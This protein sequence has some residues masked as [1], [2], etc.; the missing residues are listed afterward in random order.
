MMYAVGLAFAVGMG[1]L[2]VRRFCSER[3]P[4]LLRWLLGAALGLGIG[5]YLVFFTHLCFNWH[6]RWVPVF[7]GIVLLRILL[8]K[9]ELRGHLTYLHPDFQKLSMVSPYLLLAAIAF[10]LT[11]EAL[12]FPLGG[13]DAWSCWN[14]K[15]KF[16]YLGKEHWRDLFDP[17]LWRSNTQY[18]LLLPSINVWFWDFTGEPH[19]WVPMIN[20]ILITLLCAA[21]LLFGL[22]HLTGQW[23]MPLILTAAVFLLPFNITLSAG[24][25]SDILVGL[26]ILCALVCIQLDETLLAAMF[27][28]LLSFTKTEGLVAAGILALLIFWK[29]PKLRPAFLGTLLAAALPTIIFMLAMAPR[30]E[31][32]INGLL[33]ATKP[34][35]FERLQAVLA[36]PWFEF[37]SGKWNGLW[38]VLLAGLAL[39]WKT[40]FGRPLLIFGVFFGLYLGV[41]L[42]YYQIN[43][44]FEIG[45]WLQNTFSRI[46]FALLPSLMLWLGLAL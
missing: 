9:T 35:T 10:F 46:L 19:A 34:S 20:G 33:S 40:A 12:F 29:T 5:G 37:F 25:Y 11:C 26:Y 2:L 8:W 23:V 31:A 6:A 28:G 44:F 18:P 15:A 13:W 21:V 27:L 42:A 17:L 30:N 38:I 39:Q 22:K 7:A 3:I 24:Q 43:T 32:F 36:Y 45:W 16:I 14:L 4:E 41:V 1:Y